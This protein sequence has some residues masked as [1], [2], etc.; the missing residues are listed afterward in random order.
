[1][2]TSDAAHIDTE[3]VTQE[4]ARI[5][6]VFRALSQ[7]WTAGRGA[8]EAGGAAIGAGRLADAM[9]PPYEAVSVPLHAAGQVIP[10]LY[11]A[12]SAAGASC[13]SIYTGGD[14]HGAKACVAAAVP[15]LP[16]S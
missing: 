6:E 11:D 12:L 7:A 3:A 9:R 2:T 10:G 1:M 16:P 4:M 15:A 13:T 5:A 8:I 14:A